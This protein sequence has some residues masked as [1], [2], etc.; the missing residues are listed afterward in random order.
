MDKDQLAV[1]IKK[2]LQEELKNYTGP[3]AEKISDEHKEQISEIKN[4]A[5]AFVKE[6]PWMAV[7]IASALGFLIAS[8]LYKGD[9]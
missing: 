1:E 2:L 8:M 3:L 4:E 6:N 5:T 7:G 9:D